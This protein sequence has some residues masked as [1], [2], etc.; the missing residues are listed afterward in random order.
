MVYRAADGKYVRD[1]VQWFDLEGHVATDHPLSRAVKKF[2]ENMVQYLAAQRAKD[3]D[4]IRRYS[5]RLCGN[6]D[7]VIRKYDEML[8]SRTQEVNP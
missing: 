3:T 5:R 1:I 4:G 7:S 8:K 2:Q 6:E